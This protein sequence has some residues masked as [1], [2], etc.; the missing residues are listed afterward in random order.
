MG[1]ILA[2]TIGALFWLITQALGLGLTG[3]GHG[4][5]GAFLFS[6]PLVILYPLAFI[7]T[8]CST[9]ESVEV[10]AGI[11]AGAVVL[12]FMLAANILSGDNHYFMQMWRFEA[13]G[14]MIWLGLWAGW[15][16]LL[17]GSLIWKKLGTAGAKS[18]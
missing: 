10:E 7:R 2:G 17:V 5:Y 15:Q 9:A 4:W 13:G 11:L 14:I 12:D 3:A 16:I 6:I 1:K 8:F 18:A